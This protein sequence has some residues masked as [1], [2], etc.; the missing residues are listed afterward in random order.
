MVVGRV[1]NQMN[2]II[3]FRAD[4]SLDMGTGHVLRCLTLADSLK[5]NGD[6]CHFICR[7]HK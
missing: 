7:E 2:P 6:L 4:A 5:D 1:G 3:V